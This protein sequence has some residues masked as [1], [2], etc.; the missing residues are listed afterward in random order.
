[1]EAVN[2]VSS[3]ETLQAVLLLV[4]V[5]RTLLAESAIPWSCHSPG[6]SVNRT[7]HG[8]DQPQ[9]QF[10]TS[11][12]TTFLSS[13]NRT[14]NTTSVSLNLEP[15]CGGRITEITFH[16][17]GACNAMIERTVNYGNCCRYQTTVRASSSVRK[18]GRRANLLLTVPVTDNLRLAEGHYR[19]EVKVTLFTKHR[20]NTCIVDLDKSIRILAEDASPQHCWDECKRMCPSATAAAGAC[21]PCQTAHPVHCSC[22]PSIHAPDT[23]TSKPDR[24]T[25]STRASAVSG[26]TNSKLYLTVIYC[27]SAILGL[28][29]ISLSV[30]FIAK[31]VKATETEPTQAQSQQTQAE[32]PPGELPS[33]SMDYHSS[34]LISLHTHT[35][36]AAPGT[37][38]RVGENSSVGEFHG[39]NSAVAESLMD[40]AYKL[41]KR[42]TV[43]EVGKPS[44]RNESDRYVNVTSSVRQ[45]DPHC[46]FDELQCEPHYTAMRKP[47]FLASVQQ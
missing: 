34:S 21:I 22:Q 37:V 27:G 42:Q 26:E 11:A 12:G 4:S 2:M 13:S 43:R 31:H 40:V 9:K 41:G 8:S 44:A 6:W 18:C 29:I 24:D 38:H 39:R 5:T 20:C 3:S 14:H 10:L 28:M 23:F 32:W 7:S 30:V 19:V 25:S 36:H 46:C 47:T 1:M 16:G 45:T 33:T 17:S 15:G 35:S